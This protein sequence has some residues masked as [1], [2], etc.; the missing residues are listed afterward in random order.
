MAR[1]PLPASFF[2]I[3]LGLSGLGQAWRVAVPLWDMPR[4][5][6]ESLLLL[7][8]LTWLVL[9]LSYLLQALRNP[10]LVRN[11][12]KHPVQGSTP[13]LLAVATL[14]IALAALPYS[15]PLAY[16]LTLTGICWHLLASAVLPL[17]HRHIMARRT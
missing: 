13:A 10:Q 16:A 7:A 17:A 3:V 9:L 11:E 8:A 5:I 4:W 14:L 15:R 6:G 12:F 1:S 2:G